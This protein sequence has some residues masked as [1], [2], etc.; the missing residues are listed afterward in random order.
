[1]TGLELRPVDVDREVLDAL[2]F[3]TA[4]AGLPLGDPSILAVHALA[5]RAAA[6]GIRV[7]LGGE[8]A[9]ELFFGYRR[10]RA[11]AHLPS[12]RWLRP[13]APRWS[14][15]PAARWLRAAT[16]PDPITALLAVTPVAFGAAVLTPELAAQACWRDETVA[17]L[18][19]EWAVPM[20]P[21][22]LAQTRDRWGYLRCDL[23]PKVDIACMSAGVEAR[24][25]FLEGALDMVCAG[26]VRRWL[27]KQ[28]L[29]SAFAAELPPEVLRL[30]KTGF[31][32]P[33]DRWFRG[34]LP[35][36]DLLRE[37]TT[38]QR[39]HLRPGGIARAIDL[40]RR[41]RVDLGHGLYL[42]VACELFLR[43]F[44]AGNTVS[45]RTAAG[46]PA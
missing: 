30:P 10:Y 40:H 38:C 7:L 9:D 35:W 33:L 14:M 31:A 22:R 32:L 42:L 46:P 13:F 23:L 41:G 4:C 44:P 3:L 18:S 6:D 11:L 25:P 20:D 8:G 5:R 2:P 15:R 43:A 17:A 26:D 27:G 29:R 28:A 21:A 36:L 1:R 37:P 39:P 45:V 19:W 34:D 24:C 16:A 12:A